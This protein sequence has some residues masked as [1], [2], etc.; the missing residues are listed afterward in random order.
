MFSIKLKFTIDVLVKWFNDVF[1]SRF[2]ELDAIK[3]QEFLKEKPI[4]WSNKKMCNLRLKVSSK[5]ARR[6]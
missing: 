4:D 5:P 1:K 2:D 3:K 6:L